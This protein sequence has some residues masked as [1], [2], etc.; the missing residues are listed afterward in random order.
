MYIL[1]STLSVNYG[2]AKFL[3]IFSAAFKYGKNLK[4]KALKDRINLNFQAKH[5]LGGAK[6]TVSYTLD[7]KFPAKV[8]RHGLRG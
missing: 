8:G 1:N 6:K 5:K 2:S 3:A 7:L 4:S